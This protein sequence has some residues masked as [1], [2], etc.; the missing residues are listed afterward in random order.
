VTAGWPCRCACAALI[1]AGVSAPADPDSSGSAP[2]LRASDAERER[3]LARLSEG[4]AVGRLTHDT[5]TERVEAALTAGASAELAG[6]VADLPGP[7]RLRALVRQ[8]WQRATRAAD[9][10]LRGW[11]P[12]LTLPVGPQRRFTIGREPSCDMILADA[13]VSR[14]HASLQRESAG[15]L[16][17]DLGSTN[18]T[19]LNGWRVS[20]PMPV[21]PGDMVSFGA[22]TFV[23]TDRPG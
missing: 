9:R 21:R 19:R 6:L 23:L 13:T 1:I 22:L 20:V 3:A 17:C 15:W 18:G 11:P 16:L 2:P 8:H 14:W 5:F 10:W 12:A 4:F 7:W